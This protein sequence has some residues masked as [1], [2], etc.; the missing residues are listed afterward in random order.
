[1][2]GWKAIDELLTSVFQRYSQ[3]NDRFLVLLKLRL[4]NRLY[5]TNI[6]AEDKVAQRGRLFENFLSANFSEITYFG[7]LQI[8][9]CAYSTALT[10]S[11]GG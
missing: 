7:W 9:D 5:H 3:N 4:I 8:C 10:Q 1:M 11:E 2:S 6:T